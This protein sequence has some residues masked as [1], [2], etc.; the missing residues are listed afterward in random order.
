[1]T[2]PFKDQKEFMTKA[3]QYS[4]HWSDD[5]NMLYEQLILEEVE[6]FT[7]SKYGSLNEV[8]ELVDILVVVIGKLYSMGVD[9]E[10]AWKLVHE[11]N[12][13]KLEELSYNTEGKVMKTERSKDAKK[14]MYRKMKESFP[15][16]TDD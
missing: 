11:N 5:N 1:M 3:G 13:I 12:M 9:P 2:N 14:E 15:H 7:K 8:K 4:N 16:L 6:E 10:K